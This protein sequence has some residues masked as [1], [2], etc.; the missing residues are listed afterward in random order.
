MKET[1]TF[2]DLRELAVKEGIKDNKVSV[3]MWAKFNGYTRYKRKIR[4]NR[5]IWTYVKA[6][7]DE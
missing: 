5:I 4:D 3:G 1:I 6:K 7:K 2:D